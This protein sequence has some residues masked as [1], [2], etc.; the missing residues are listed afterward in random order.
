M[1]IDND[2]FMNQTLTC[3][4]TQ[5][6]EPTL[7]WMGKM[8]T[9]ETEVDAEDD[10]RPNRTHWMG[11]VSVQCGPVKFPV[12]NMH[13]G[14]SSCAMRIEFESLSLSLTSIL[15]VTLSCEHFCI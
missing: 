5:L 10:G 15:D 3:L 11:F 7:K 9:D 1:T 14:R 4:N 13:S 8:M 6:K 2:L 12:F